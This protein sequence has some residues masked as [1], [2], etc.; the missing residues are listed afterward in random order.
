MQ[1]AAC[2]WEVATPRQNHADCA[3]QWADIDRFHRSKGYSSI[4]YNMGAC[5]HGGTFTGRGW[6]VPSAA[7]GTRWANLNF[8]AVCA[9]TGPGQAHTPELRKAMGSL[10]AEGLR[11]SSPP[12]DVSPH[13]RFFNTACCGDIIR[14]WI[15]AGLGKSGVTPPMNQEIT[16][17]WIEQVG[18]GSLIA[19]PFGFR[20]DQDYAN[21]AKKRGVRVLTGESKTGV[22]QRAAYAR[23]QFGVVFQ[24]T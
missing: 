21:W 11:R 18:D 8:F 14:T 4:A 3:R 1:G 5:I 13:S 9:M 16:D 20:V 22:D 7:N 6:G 24:D 19:M 10:V 12:R 15:T 23:K 17:M 2:H